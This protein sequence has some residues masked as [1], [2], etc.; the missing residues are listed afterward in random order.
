[1]NG[2]RVVRKTWKAIQNGTRP[3]CPKCNGKLFVGTLAHIAKVVML[4]SSH[5]GPEVSSPAI[6]IRLL[7]EEDSQ[8][9]AAQFP[10]HKIRLF[11]VTAMCDVNIYAEDPMKALNAAIDTAPKNHFVPADCNVVAVLQ[12]E[13]DV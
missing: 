1:M 10:K 13:E 12:E 11:R 9:L 2:G 3:S 5:G 7:E 8:K 4:L 6:L